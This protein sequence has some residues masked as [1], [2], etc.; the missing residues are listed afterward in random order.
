MQGGV[1]LV[2]RIAE[3]HVAV[4]GRAEGVARDFIE[5]ISFNGESKI[6]KREVLPVNPTAP[7]VI[8]N[9][10]PIAIIGPPV[11]AGKAEGE[12]VGAQLSYRCRRRLCTDLFGS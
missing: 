2:K 10:P 5:E 8:R 12:L 11:R 6:L 4:D 9:A 3:D 7:S 1:F